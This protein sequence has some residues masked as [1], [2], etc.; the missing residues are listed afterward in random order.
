MIDIVVLLKIRDRALFQEFETEALSILKTYNGELITAFEPVQD[1]TASD[2][3]DEVHCLRF[4]DMNSLNRY[5]ADPLLASLSEL[6]SHAIAETRVLV[7]AN[8]KNYKA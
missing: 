6:R 5:R 1:D 7:S 4:P 2:S 8:H 3:V